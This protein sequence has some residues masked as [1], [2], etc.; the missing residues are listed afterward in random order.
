MGSFMPQ[1][2][3]HRENKTGNQWIG[4]WV[5][6]GAG[7]DAAERSFLPWR[8]S[9]PD[10]SAVKLIKSVT[11]SKHLLHSRLKLTSKYPM[12]TMVAVVPFY[13]NVI[14]HISRET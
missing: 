8:K 14:L 11:Y 10:S 13:K 12:T 3:C 2:L 1:P 7:L 5:G 4:G 6:S 9:N